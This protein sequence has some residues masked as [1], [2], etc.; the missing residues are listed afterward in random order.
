[1]NELADCSGVRAAKGCG[2][3]GSD[4]LFVLHD[5]SRSAAIEE[6]RVAHELRFAATET[7]IS[8]DGVVIARG[9]H[10]EAGLKASEK[11]DT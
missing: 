1:L 3:M 4:I 7:E 8:N 5:H 10:I 2:A 11:A 6:F 9:S